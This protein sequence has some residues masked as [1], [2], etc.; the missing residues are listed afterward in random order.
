MIH[1]PDQPYVCHFPFYYLRT[2][3]RV[4]RGK[5][6]EYGILS[7]GRFMHAVKTGDITFEMQP[8]SVFINQ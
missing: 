8:I 2:I 1:F 6:Y 5:R 4:I 7:Y 3:W